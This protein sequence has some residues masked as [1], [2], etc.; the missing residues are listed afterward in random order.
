MSFLGWLY[1]HWDQ[2]LQYF[3]FCCIEGQGASVFNL[4]RNF[5]S[6]EEY[7][8]TNKPQRADRMLP[9][10]PHRPSVTCGFGSLFRK[11]LTQ[12]PRLHVLTLG[13]YFKL[14]DVRPLVT[15]A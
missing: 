5:G 10:T 2:R 3:G 6:W 1:I 14:T 4:I 15:F 12:G 13:H 7:L 11:Y 8:G 9:M